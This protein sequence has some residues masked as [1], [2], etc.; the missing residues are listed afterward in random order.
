MPPRGTLPIHDFPGT[1][2][3]AELLPLPSADT[4]PFYQALA[5]GELRLQRCAECGRLRY[6]IAPVCP[7]CAAPDFEW[8]PAPTGGEVHAWVRYHRAF[9]PAFAG[10]VPYV[11]VSVALERGPRLVGRLLSAAEPA[12]AMP[13]EAVLEQWADGSR[14]PAF[15]PRE[16]GGAG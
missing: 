6:P 14:V 5:A 1:G 12:T 11:V 7:W 13:V 16:G 4:A 8:D 15:V 10:I 3:G 2:I 9:V